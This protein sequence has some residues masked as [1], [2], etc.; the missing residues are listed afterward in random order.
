MR[1]LPQFALQ[2]E[3]SV[4]S[5]DIAPRSVT[6]NLLRPA[7]VHKSYIDAVQCRCNAC[8]DTA[9]RPHQHKT[10]PYEYRFGACLGRGL[11]EVTDAA[12]HKHAVLN[13]VDQGTACRDQRGTYFSSHVLRALSNHW[14]SWAG[15]PR[16]LWT[17]RVLHFRQ[18]CV[19][20]VYC[21]SYEIMTHPAP[22]ETPEAIGRVERH[23]GIAKAMFKK[24]RPE[25]QVVGFDQVQQCLNEIAIKNSPAR[26]G[27][28][29]A[30]GS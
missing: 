4:V 26:F 17:E 13:M 20:A 1:K 12:G 28:F 9:P 6:I 22:L 2:S 21:G 14:F 27:E 3:D 23:G 25:V 29:S 7:R 8:D 18:R 10:L 19:A 15:R 30:N 11:L 16:S 24:T 5:L